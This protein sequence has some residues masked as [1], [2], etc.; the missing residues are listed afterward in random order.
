[1]EAVEEFFFSHN[2]I[3]WIKFRCRKCY[4]GLTCT[5]GA[6]YTS[7]FKDLVNISKNVKYH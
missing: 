3:V 1:M 7:D 5:V 4:T 6:N 2:F